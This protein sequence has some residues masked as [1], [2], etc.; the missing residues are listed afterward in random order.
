MISL[1]KNHLMDRTLDICLCLK[2]IFYQK[3]M[4]ILSKKSLH[5]QE[6]KRGMIIDLFSSDESI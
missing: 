4:S 5:Y 3:N 2:V 6:V 1:Q